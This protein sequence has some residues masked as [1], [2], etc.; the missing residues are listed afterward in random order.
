[1]C[2]AKFRVEVGALNAVV[3]CQ[4]EPAGTVDRRVLRG[5]SGVPLIRS[6]WMSVPAWSRIGR[7]GGAENGPAPVTVGRAVKVKARRSVYPKLGDRDGAGG[8]W[9]SPCLV[10]CGLSAGLKDGLRVQPPASPQHQL[11]PDRGLRINSERRGAAS[12]PPARPADNPRQPLISW[13]ER[14]ADILNSQTRS[15]AIA[16]MLDLIGFVMT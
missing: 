8:S 2:R 9:L 13:T 1:M 3:A 10:R 4:R 11:F 6:W 7:G 15:R 12:E 16:C 14:N 5:R